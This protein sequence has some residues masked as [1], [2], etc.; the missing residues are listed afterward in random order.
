MPFV[1]TIPLRYKPI[2]V[3]KCY[4]DSIS[5]LSAATYYGELEGS[6][7]DLLSRGVTVDGKADVRDKEE[8]VRRQTE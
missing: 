6:L 8:I 3:S 7:R 2:E 1:D 5:R 4:G